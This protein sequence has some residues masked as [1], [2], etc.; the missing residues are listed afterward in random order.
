[1]PK[2]TEAEQQAALLDAIEPALGDTPPPADPPPAEDPPADPPPSDP[3][4]AD[5]PADPPADPEVDPPADPPVDPEKP[6]DPPPAD[7][8]PPPEEKPK[9]PSDE[10]G[11]LPADVPVKTRERF[12]AL[13]TKFDE[14]TNELE[15]ER[16]ERQ[17][18]EKAANE[19]LTVV[20][21]AGS[22][23]QF[24]RALQYL[25]DVNEG[26]PESLERAY[27]AMKGELEVLAKALGKPA[28]GFDPLEAHPDLKAEVEDERITKERALEIAE[29]R[30]RAKVAEVHGTR[31]T[32]SQT[33][34]A[35]VATAVE[36]LKALGVELQ[37]SDPHF[38]AKYERLELAINE[39]V[40]TRPPSEWA[41]RVRT[42][43]ERVPAPA[44]A[45]TPAAPRVPNAL[46]P[47]GSPGGAAVTKPPANVL[48]AV[49]EGMRRAGMA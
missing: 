17:H 21:S 15:N 2:Q 27:T 6:A 29:A 22:P 47:G 13:K 11:E 37:K 16:V 3:P 33:R 28:P 7:P 42:A 36:E 38:K 49:E 48:E 30:S 8:P 5:P 23:D 35:Q 25:H 26:S 18:Y 24:G 43:Y 1:M 32:E 20:K 31:K 9:R 14:R 10:F 4:A 44:V 19:W 39:I 46:R 45:A 41:A 34:Q 12:E 40:E